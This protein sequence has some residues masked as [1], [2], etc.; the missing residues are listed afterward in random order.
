MLTRVL[1]RSRISRKYSKSLYLLRTEE[2][3][4]LNAGMLVRVTIS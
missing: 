3:L 2:Y 1:S 4:S